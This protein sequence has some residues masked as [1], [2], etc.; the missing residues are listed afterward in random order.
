M[1]P[2]FPPP[3]PDPN[4][5]SLA[6]L[7]H[8]PPGTPPYYLPVQGNPPRLRNAPAPDRALL[9]PQQDQRD[10]DTGDDT[11]SPARD[12]L[13][14]NAPGRGLKRARPDTS[15]TETLEHSEPVC[16]QRRTEPPEPTPKEPAK[17]FV[18]LSPAGSIVNILQK[19]SKDRS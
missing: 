19:W 12:A 16:K 11:S 8:L 4:S 18:L 5:S 9:N 10:I 13:P 7:N 2:N 3:Q 15:D 17:A 6:Y 14:D 1:N